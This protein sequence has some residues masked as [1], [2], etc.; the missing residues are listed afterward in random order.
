VD[1]MHDCAIIPST[2]FTSTCEDTPLRYV[3]R[4]FMHDSSIIINNSFPSFPNTCAKADC[5]ATFAHIMVAGKIGELYYCCPSQREDP[6]Y[7]MRDT[8]CDR[9]RQGY[10]CPFLKGFNAGSGVGVSSSSSRTFGVFFSIQVVC[11]RMLM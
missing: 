1:F 8:Q 5:N 3:P 2:T 9:T 11:P 10:D 7:G 6:P 4:N